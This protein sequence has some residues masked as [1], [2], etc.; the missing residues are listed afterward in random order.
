MGRAEGS[1][2]RV[3]AINPTQV[4]PALLQAPAE[5]L[6]SGGLVAFPTETVYGLG[7][8]ALD[9]DAVARLY[10][11]K[12]R[13]TNN[14][15][16][17]HI[18]PEMPVDALV[19]E[20]PTAA[21]QLAE[22]FW[23]GPLTLVVKR[24]AR[25]PDAVTARADTVALRVPTHP[26]AQALIR[27]AGVPVAAP[28]ANRSG[29]LSPTTAEHVRRSLGD[30][31]DWLVDGGACPGGIEST[32]VDVTVSPPRIL[33]PGL[34]TQAQLEAIVGPVA[35]PPVGIAVGVPLPAPGMLA[36]H[37]APRTAL[38]LAADAEELTL[39]RDTYTRAGLRVCV[40]TL[41][42]NP[43]EAARTLYA[44]LHDRDTGEYDRILTLLPPDTPTWAAIRDRLT[45]A[46][47]TD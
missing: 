17:V 21:V 12:G 41:P 31:I 15:L 45:R 19:A 10:E 8:H 6:R 2:L 38:E 25:V 33:R 5:T 28:S 26:I 36:K 22:A 44:S 1:T 39:L 7:V 20:W 47:A 9:P 29:E 46:A 24:S 18:T 42:D 11:A 40:L 4:D 16:I 37:Y 14:P 35:A 23:P 27:M 34:V 13:P 30:R 3:V 32:V 43:A